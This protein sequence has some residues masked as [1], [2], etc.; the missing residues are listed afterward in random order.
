MG[1]IGTFGEKNRLI[2]SLPWVATLL[3]VKTHTLLN[4]CHEHDEED[5]RKRIKNRNPYLA[6]DGWIFYDW[7]HAVVLCILPCSR[8]L[9]NERRALVRQQLSENLSKSSQLLL[10]MNRPLENMH[11]K[12]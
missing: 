12:P 10:F 8:K 6:S 3:G 2:V 9:S 5:R 11:K 7:V 1:E 4:Y